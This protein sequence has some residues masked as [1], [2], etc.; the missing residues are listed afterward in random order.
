MNK[1]TG[2]SA[3]ELAEEYDQGL[4]DESA[5]KHGKRTKADAR[6]H[7]KGESSHRV[8]RMIINNATNGEEKL[9]FYYLKSLKRSG[10]DLPDT[11]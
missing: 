7:D 3:S 2:K 11:A 6:E 8:D 5:S 4:H 10:N 9:N 1:N